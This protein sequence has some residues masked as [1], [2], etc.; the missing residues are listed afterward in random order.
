MGSPRTEG[1]SRN[2]PRSSAPLQICNFESVKTYKRAD[3]VAIAVAASLT[4][5]IVTLWVVILR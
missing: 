1:S 3:Y 2:F 4:A 5:M